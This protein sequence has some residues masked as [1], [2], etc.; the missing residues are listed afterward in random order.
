MA[1]NPAQWRLHAGQYLGEISALSFLSLP[2]HSFLP[3]LL[4]GTGSQIVLDDIETGE[5][6]NTFKVFE[7]IRV[8]GISCSSLDSSSSDSFTEHA[9]QVAVFGERRV[10]LFRLH[11][12][13]NKGQQ[14]RTAVS[15]ELILIESLPR[16][17]HWVMDVCFLED[18]LCSG[19]KNH[20]V[21]GLSNNS[22]CFWD[23]CRSFLSIEVT[24]TERCLLYSMRF[25]GN[26]IES[27]RVASGTI[28]NDIIIWKLV[29]SEL[30][31]NL[32]SSAERSCHLDTLSFNNDVLLG[33]QYNSVN[34]LK[35]KGHEGSIF[36]ISWS[37]DGSKVISASDDRSAL[38]WHVIE[39]KEYSDGLKEA[40]APDVL[41]DLVLFGHNA[42]VWDCYISDTI[43]ITAGED[44]TCRVWNVDG[45]ELMVIKEHIGRGIWRC[46]YDPGSSVLVTAG[47]DSAVKV[48]SIPVPSAAKI[49]NS[50]VEQSKQKRE[51][52][53]ICTLNLVEQLGPINSKSEYVRCLEFAR[54]DILYVATNHGYVYHVKLENPG[55]VKWTKLVRVS[56]EVPIICMDLLLTGDSHLSSDQE[57]QVA[58][59][60]GKGNAT[61]LKVI[62]SACALKEVR[63]FSWSA[64]KERQLLGIYWCKQ[65]GCRYLFTANP[66]G[67][68]N[69]WCIHEASEG[70]K[71]FS[72]TSLIAEF[73]SCFGSRIM[74]LDASFQEEVLVAGDQRGNLI[75]FP[76][77]KDFQNGTLIGSESK[78]K[79]LTYFKG[80]HGISSVSSISIARSKFNEVE[81]SSTGGD[82][83]IC[84]FVFHEDLQSLEFLGMEQVKELSLIQS[85]FANSRLEEDMRLE[86]YAIGFASTDFIIWDLISETKV[87]AVPCGGWRRPYTY[88]LGT[89]PRTQNCFAYLKDQ[90]IHV[91]RLWFPETSGRRLPQLLH[92]QF[93]G[94]EIH[95]LCFVFGSLLRSN[96]DYCHS[97]KSCWIATGCE[98]GTVRLTRYASS[99]RS[100]LTSKYLGEHVGG[101]AVKSLCFISKIYTFRN[102]HLNTSYNQNIEHPSKD[103]QDCQMLLISVGAKQVLT[104]WALRKEGNQKKDLFSMA[105]QNLENIAF[106]WLS[107]HMPPKFSSSRKN[108]KT[109]EMKQE[110]AS[111]LVVWEHN[112]ND[113]RYLAVTAFLVRSP[114][115][116]LTVCFVVV[117]CSDATLTLRALLLPSRL[118]YDVALLVPHSSPVLALQHLVIPTYSSNG[119]WTQNGNSYLVVCGSTDGSIT[120]WDMTDTVEDFMLKIST[121]QPEKF[122]DCKGR[123]RTG[124]GSQGGRWWRSLS[125]QSS[126]KGPIGPV[127]GFNSTKESEHIDCQPDQVTR[128]ASSVEN[129]PTI[130]SS[131][132]ICELWPLHVVDS[133]HQSG[134][135]CLHISRRSKV[136]KDI[137]SD[138]IFCV[139]S[140]GDDQA[141]SCIAFDWA[142]QEV[143]LRLDVKEQISDQGKGINRKS[144]FH[145]ADNR[146]NVLCQDRIES[147]H[148]SAVKG[149]WTDGD[150]VFSTGLDQRVRCWHL[151][152]SGELFEHSHLV[153]SVP[154][155]ETLDAHLCE[156]NRY[157]IAVGGRGMQMI[158]FSTPN[159]PQ[160]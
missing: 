14:L 110:V 31:S 15:N 142:A 109:V 155:P 49:E 30:A 45:T 160:Q 97:S 119:G 106:K 102:E 131:L 28:F 67:R 101:S 55:E 149:I 132:G 37:L 123:P 141:V 26:C 140:G 72:V 133:V 39:Q 40:S 125:S 54:E 148:S 50:F 151:S 2:D 112:E 19:K 78:I 83:C 88:Y 154:E 65:L 42:R 157:Q 108:L 43:I 84:H 127:V 76:L 69:L 21:V 29:A 24:N 46:L 59:G 13:L 5:I 98:D 139:L 20:L 64:E 68:I 158:E 118:W 74:C 18:S 144:Y 130:D 90:N 122:I 86:N 128:M 61:V 156:R 135:N 107:S 47:F 92:M 9:F 32:T 38:V 34:M 103:S 129:S 159:F 153:V 11:L 48:H 150:W 80:A 52:F 58:V 95:S 113:W 16:F 93:H 66:G 105:S 143:N 85:V 33:K 75:L 27:L 1:T 91:Y 147:A 89:A 100:W 79:A 53:T 126:E 56:E 73:T 117:A 25:W 134:V 104:S 152:E 124:R 99:T 60:D 3:L 22:V 10:K 8:H 41:A 17:S 81:I 77:P 82:G 136:L 57:V 94:R 115:C 6:F 87:L 71:N 63:S 12:N 116:R 146:L 120:F 111:K 114:G 121:I 138:S 23:I 44:C 137:K 96:N 36:R 62:N 7:G 145:G 4:V 70:P 35:L 51:V